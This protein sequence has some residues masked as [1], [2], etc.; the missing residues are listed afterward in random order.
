MLAEI[1]A[2]DQ[3]LDAVVTPLV[4]LPIYATPLP[5]P[6][7]PVIQVLGLEDL[8]I[9]MSS[10][11]CLVMW[12]EMLGYSGEFELAM[13]KSYNISIIGLFVCAVN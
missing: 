3:T 5:P 2:E 13:K 8:V 6:L 9:I 1:A 11:T 7:E 12:S 4:K 10:K